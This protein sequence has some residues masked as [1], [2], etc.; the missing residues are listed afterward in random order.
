MYNVYVLR[1]DTGYR[2]TKT[3]ELCEQISL[4]AVAFVYLSFNSLHFNQPFEQYESHQNVGYLQQP[5]FLGLV[6]E[7]EKRITIWNFKC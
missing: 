2:Y 1:A 5:I 7:T 6:L 3:N 4:D